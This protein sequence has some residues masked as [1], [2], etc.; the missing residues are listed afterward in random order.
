MLECLRNHNLIA[1]YL[2][3]FIEDLPES[4]QE[5]VEARTKSYYTRFQ[6]VDR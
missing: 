3:H 4:T 5:V 1:T 2:G 6:A